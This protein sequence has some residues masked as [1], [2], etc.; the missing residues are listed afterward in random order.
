M[1]FPAL[2]VNQPRET[3]S[4]FGEG[5][6]CHHHLRGERRKS[7]LTV[8]WLSRCQA[9]GGNTEYTFTPIL[10]ANDVAGCEDSGG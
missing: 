8:Q 5:A 4:A 2:D 10:D 6:S 7:G 9:V 1:T 3:T